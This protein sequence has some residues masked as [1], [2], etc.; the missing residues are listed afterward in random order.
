MY[1]FDVNGKDEQIVCLLMI[2]GLVQIVMLSNKDLIIYYFIVIVDKVFQ[3]WEGFKG[4]F[5]KGDYMIIYFDDFLM[6]QV[7]FNNYD[8]FKIVLKLV[9]FKN[10]EVFVI[11]GVV[12]VYEGLYIRVV[13]LVNG[14]Y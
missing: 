9:N 4:V 7:V 2:E 12:V 1:I 6:V 3:V 11:L 8:F 13:V 10:E 5:V 14:L